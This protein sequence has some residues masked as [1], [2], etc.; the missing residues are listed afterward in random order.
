MVEPFPLLHVALEC[1]LAPPH[2]GMVAVIGYMDG[3]HLGHQ[4]LIKAAKE[5]A[6][7]RPLAAIVFEPHPRRVFQPDT[8]PFLLT[9]LETKASLLHAQGVTSVFALPFAEALYKQSPEEFVGTT[10]HQRLGVAG[11][12][13]GTDFQFGAGRSGDAAALKALAEGHG[14]TAHAITPVPDPSGIK[15]SSSTVRQALRD[16]DP[17]TATLHLG[18]PWQVR[19]EVIEGR[20]LARTLNFPTAN[21]LLSEYVRPQYGVYV[22]RAHTARGLIG[23]VANV[24]VR[25]TVDGA[26]ERLEAHLFD[27]DEDLYGEHLHIDVLHFLRPEQK[28]DGLDALKAQITKDGEA[29]R[30]WLGANPTP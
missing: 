22:I 9:D 10:L 3:V 6:G 19:G 2:R 24:G 21:L 23:G 26:E 7:D 16:G 4:V 30:A 13:T 28:F 8:P 27:F 29:A 14:M 1:D 12:V 18:R 20:R 15:Y 17:A 25:P 11:I 5:A